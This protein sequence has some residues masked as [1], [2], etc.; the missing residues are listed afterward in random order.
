MRTIATHL[1]LETASQRPMK[2]IF[3]R[4]DAIERLTN[5]S[6]SDA[7]RLA[8]LAHQ[9]TPDARFDAD[10]LRPAIRHGETLVFA[11]RSRGRI[12][13]SATA[14]RFTTPTDE[15]WRIED[16]VVDGKC[17]GKGLGRRLMD[18]VLLALKRMNVRKVELTSRPSRVAANT[19]Y[20]SLGFTR[21]TT[22]VYECILPRP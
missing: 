17:R 10:R 2:D 3:R 7:R 21:R 22:N 15:H 6:E 19:L 12:I 8:E 1:R 9:L 11:I 14:V 13:A 4:A 5:L 20:R 16:V 18:G